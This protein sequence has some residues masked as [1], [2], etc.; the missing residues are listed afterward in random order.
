VRRL[1]Y[2][3]L[4]AAFA[5]LSVLLL[6]SEFTLE[7]FNKYV[8]L[9]VSAVMVVITYLAATS[10]NKKTKA[11]A[12]KQNRNSLIFYGKIVFG[13]YAV[14]LAVFMLLM[15][16]GMWLFGVEKVQ[17]HLLKNSSVVLFGLAIL[18]APMLWK[19]LR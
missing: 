17:A 13:S 12:P 15:V 6:V 4:S 9:G 19:R 1:V 10:P 5:G 11:E 18:A 2:G 7:G 14:A 3:S 8:L 16:L